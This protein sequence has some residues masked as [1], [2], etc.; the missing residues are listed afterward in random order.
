M[1]VRAPRVPVTRTDR[2]A[3]A[4]VKRGYR[5][6]I[7]NRVCDMIESARWHGLHQP[8]LLQ[9]RFN[10]RGEQRVRLERSRL[11]LGMK[12]HADEPRMLFVFDDLR[13]HAI[14]RHA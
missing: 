7:T 8:A 1:I 13:Q 11:Q 9:R 10:E 2:E 6:E 4:P 12:L 3:K 5:V 14:R